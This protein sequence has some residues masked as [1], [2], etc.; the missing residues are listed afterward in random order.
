MINITF[1]VLSHGQNWKERILKY[2]FFFSLPA[3]IIKYRKL[4]I[5]EAVYVNII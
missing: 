1:S 2:D 3:G 5:S 4:K